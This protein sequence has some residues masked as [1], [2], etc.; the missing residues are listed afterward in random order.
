MKNQFLV[1]FGIGLAC[2]GLVVAGVLFMQRGARVGLT[3][4]VLKVR[5]APLDDNS[6]V[7]V[8]DF[9]FSNPG[10]VLFVVRSVTVVLE[11]KDGK[12]YDG[13][14]VAE[15]DAKRLFEGIPLLGQ[16]FTDTLVERDKVP[17]H[18]F[19]DRM[20]AARFD[21]LESRLEARKRFLLRIEEV[22]G[23]VSE[24]SEK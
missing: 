2:I 19:Q 7:V 12:Q 21:A 5:T 23:L 17:G 9:R 10:N 20:V 3:G 18:T 11:E 14:T 1:A 13:R 22:D 16:K 6:S 8:L 15:M 4:S 24:I